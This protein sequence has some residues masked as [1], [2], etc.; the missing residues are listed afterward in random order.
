V[1]DVALMD[2]TARPSLAVPIS[3]INDCVSFAFVMNLSVSQQIIPPADACT[4][5]VPGARLLAWHESD[6]CPD[7]RYGSRRFVPGGP[8]ENKLPE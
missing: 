4:P 6:D 1:K 3:I 5:V 7:M 8:L 2:F